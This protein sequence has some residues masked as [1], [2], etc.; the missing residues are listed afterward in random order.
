MKKHN[1]ISPG[2]VANRFLELALYRQPPLHNTLSGLELEY[3][4]LQ[5]YT[6]DTG[7]REAKISFHVGQGTQDIG[8][9]NA[10]DVLFDCLPSVPVIFRVKDHDGSPTTASF[11]ITD[12]IERIVISPGHS[13]GGS[14]VTKGAGRLTWHDRH[15]LQD[16][17][18]RM[19]LALELPWV[20]IGGGH[21][22][23]KVKHLVRIYLL[24]SR[25]LASDGQ[26][27]D[28][29]FQA[30][31]YRSDGEHVNLPPG[32]YEIK[33]TRGPEYVPQT[34]RVTIPKN[35]NRDE[36]SFQLKRWTNL[37]KLGWHSA[38]HHV[39][40]AGCSHYE[41]PKEGV[42]P[43]HMWRQALG[44]D[45]NVASVLNWG[46]CWYHQKQFFEGKVHSL[47]TDKN[48][49]RYDVEVSGF[50]SSHS[51]HLCLL[52]LK[53]DDYPGTT[54][55]ESWSSWTLPILKWAKSQGGVVGYAH[56]GWGLEPIKPTSYFPNFI[57]PKFDGIGAN[58][59]IVTVTHDAI[60]FFSTGDTP[61]PPGNSTCGITPSIQVFEPTSA[62]KLIFPVFLTNGLA[63]PPHM[64]SWKGN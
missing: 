17:N 34:K 1:A 20:E 58:K 11:T 36:V 40:A 26:Y 54:R 21:T 63:W 16:Q 12:G 56:S 46:P 60:D 32:V 37:A 53:V 59:Y 9:Q 13:A 51:G 43:E 23:L 24:P 18:Y 4:V 39:H 48:L 47:S 50:P 62:G 28:F 25:R 27:P 8:F 19:N 44:E 6:R 10:V 38:D 3:T 22:P 7:K 14:H 29:F 5:I 42:Q 15:I 57:M 64:P 2:E 35:V 31:I 52:K 45:L 61:P 55:I 30:Q 33:F 41:S 49:M